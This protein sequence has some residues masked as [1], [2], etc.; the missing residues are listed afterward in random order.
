MATLSEAVAALE[1]ELATARS[2]DAEH[3]AMKR[4]CNALPS[5]RGLRVAAAALRDSSE[6]QLAE[7]LRDVAGLMEEWSKTA[8]ARASTKP[9]PAPKPKT[10]DWCVGEAIAI[11]G[12]GEE[13]PTLC[14]SCLTEYNH[15][16]TLRPLIHP[17]VCVRH[18]AG[19]DA[20][21]C[22]DGCDYLC[23]CPKGHWEVC[24][25]DGK[26]KAWYSL[27]LIKCVLEEPKE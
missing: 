4:V 23:N 18:V 25:S 12:D 19:W 3:E 24:L 6:P 26:A 7:Y 14:A 27:H 1:R 2:R 8:V 20:M 11:T 10:C 13:D 9:A 22:R 15:A 17:G 16:E 21:V 5:P